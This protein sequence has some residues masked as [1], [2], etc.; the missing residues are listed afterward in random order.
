MKAGLKISDKPGSVNEAAVKEHSER[1]F[2][3]ANGKEI[4][5]AEFEHYMLVNCHY[6]KYVV[7]RGKGKDFP[8]ALVFPDQALFTQPDYI[9]TPLEGCFCPRNMTEFS[10]CLTGCIKLVNN[11]LADTWE[12]VRIAAIIN[13][14]T[15]Q[16]DNG[17]FNGKYIQ[18]I[19][20]MYAGNNPGNSNI[21]FIEINNNA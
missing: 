14:D 3:L 5:P 6:V 11:E 13:D 1:I 4:D 12:K 18:I 10:R 7:V 2:N 17:K 21:R 15:L 19:E 9:V 16:P 20:D 8:V